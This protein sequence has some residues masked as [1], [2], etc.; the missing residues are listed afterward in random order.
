M[1]T[2]S[3][4]KTAFSHHGSHSSGPGGF[5]LNGAYRNQG[6][7]GQSGNFRP[8]DTTI[9]L[10]DATVVKSSVLGTTGMIATKYRWIGRPVPYV[11][12]VKPADWRSQGNYL[13]YLRKKRMTEC[14][15]ESLVK[16]IPAPLESYG[17]CA[18]GISRCT[19][20]PNMPGKTGAMSASELLERSDRRNCD[21]SNEFDGNS[22]PT[23]VGGVC[24]ISG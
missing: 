12:V 24:G 10:E 6:Y 1:G 20:I 4:Q 16:E 2:K 23:N 9:S 18:Y 19:L 22:R 21:I 14:G 17:A 7:V 5:S 3:N 15:T 13:E 8:H 11:S